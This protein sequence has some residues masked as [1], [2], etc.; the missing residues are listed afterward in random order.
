MSQRTV[1]RDV[2]ALTLAGIPVY[3]EQGKGG[4]ISLMPGFV[5]DRSILSE[6]E[7][8]EIL[9]A[10]QGLVSIRTVE[11]NQVLQKLSAMFNKNLPDWVGADFS[12]WGSETFSENNIFTDFKT[13]ILERRIAE[14]DYYGT[15]GEKTRRRVEP[16]Q[17]WFK[18]K[19]WY[20]KCFCLTRQDLRQFK[21]TRVRDLSVTNAHF[22]PR[23]FAALPP[24]P[25]EPRRPDVTFKL[26]IAR[27][28]GYRAHDWFDE[29][30]MEKR[31]DGSIVASV[32]WPE[33]DWVYGFILSFGEHGEVLEPEHVRE[34]IREKARKIAEKY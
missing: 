33:D 21:L 34:I 14:F 3:T 16:I 25:G 19:A 9:S 1:Y 22:A 6:R 24:S 20:V 13:A 30:M 7:Q 17:L 31:R 26:K 28:M 32:T 15:S 5:L 29:S 10:V 4:G 27:E 2:D 18:A 11:T 8:S 12:H 23:D